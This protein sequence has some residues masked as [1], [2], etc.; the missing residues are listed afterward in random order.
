MKDLKQQNVIYE[1][2][3][4]FAK[5]I[6]Q[7]AIKNVMKI[8]KRVQDSY[9]GHMSFNSITQKVM[10]IV[11]LMPDGYGIRMSFNANEGSIIFD[12]ASQSWRIYVVKDPF[13]N[14]IQGR[15]RVAED[16]YRS[17]NVNVLFLKLKEKEP[18]FLVSYVLECKEKT[19]SFTNKE[20]LE[21][22]FKHFDV[23][24]GRYIGKEVSSYNQS[25]S[26]EQGSVKT[27]ESKVVSFRDFIEKIGEIIDKIEI[28]KKS[29]IDVTFDYIKDKNKTEIPY[30]KFEYGNNVQLV[31]VT[32]YINNDIT[33]LLR[34]NYVE[35][36]LC[37]SNRD[38]ECKR[39]NENI[40]FHYYKFKENSDEL[41][42]TR[43]YILGNTP[44]HSN[45]TGRYKGNRKK[46]LKYFYNST[47]QFCQEIENESITKENNNNYTT[48][49][50]G[51]FAITTSIPYIAANA[52]RLIGAKSNTTCTDL[53][54]VLS[55]RIAN[56]DNEDN[57]PE[58]NDYLL[59]ILVSVGSA[60]TSTAFGIAYFVCRRKSKALEEGNGQQQLEEGEHLPIQGEQPLN[61]VS[62]AERAHL[63]STIDNE[64]S[65][66]SSY[67][68]TSSHASSLASIAENGQ[69]PRSNTLNHTGSS[70]SSRSGTVSRTRSLSST[71]EGSQTNSD[72]EEV[73]AKGNQG[74][75]RTS[76]E[77]VQRARDRS[78]RSTNIT[79]QIVGCF[80]NSC[81]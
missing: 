3:W 48:A 27:S 65:E 12:C 28:Q 10:E 73:V 39:D 1:D 70:S 72:L 34:K 32:S 77:D 78:S 19:K 38:Y 17:G 49:A 64:A 76:M 18:D 58:I 26:T 21:N 81:S 52:L 43:Q 7:D 25:V 42:L 2:K 66:L 55:K 67:S 9:D 20:M 47:Q 30:I 35:C 45:N 50:Y 16:H 4:S 80:R 29:K 51:L 61:S 31:V 63:S 54:P 41:A 53:A 60:I 22:Y 75:P 46:V 56:Y 23:E 44:T 5:K 59:P 24:Y 40:Q 71:G 62:S 37:I 57:I 74:S 11:K 14:D 15:N 33:S 69:L 68:G 6:A 79:N 36:N 13:E 8:A